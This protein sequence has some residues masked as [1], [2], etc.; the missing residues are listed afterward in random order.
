MHFGDH[1][2]QALTRSV[3]VYYNN[4]LNAGLAIF[5]L[6]GSQLLGYGYAGLLQDLLVKPTKCFWPT[7]SAYT[8]SLREVERCS[9]TFNSLHGQPVP[10]VA[11]RQPDDLEARPSL[12]DR[13]PSHVCLGDHSAV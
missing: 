8:S 10:G 4:T 13:V 9:P 5:T 7:T 6:I 12:L 1:V 2:R 11:L 3:A